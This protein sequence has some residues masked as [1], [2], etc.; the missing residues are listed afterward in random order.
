MDEEDAPV[1][2]TV[3]HLLSATS[4]YA[5]VLEPLGYGFTGTF[6]DSVSF[7]ITEPDFFLEQRTVK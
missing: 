7:G 6:N 5:S 1:T 2:L 4:F 3:S